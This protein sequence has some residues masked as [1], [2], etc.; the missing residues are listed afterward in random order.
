MPK[1]VCCERSG[2]RLRGWA[3]W[4]KCPWM[5][6]LRGLPKIFIG[7]GGLPGYPRRGGMGPEMRCGHRRRRRGG[8]SPGALPGGKRGHDLRS[9][10]CTLRGSLLPRIADAG[11]S[12][13]RHSHRDRPKSTPVRPSPHDRDTCSPMEESGHPRPSPREGTASHASRLNAT[14][15][16]SWKALR[17]GISL[18]DARV[19]RAS[20]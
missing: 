11:C 3:G 20:A 7:H 1:P 13:R 8:R 10:R 18:R 2:N 17:R 6:D 14:G 5:R 16:P 19:S 12:R 15:P 9:P 4:V